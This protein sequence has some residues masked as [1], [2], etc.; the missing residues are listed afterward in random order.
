[1]ITLMKK[2]KGFSQKPIEGIAAPFLPPTPNDLKAWNNT[3]VM[4]NL[5]AIDLKSIR[6]IRDND[7]EYI[8]KYKAQAEAERSKLQK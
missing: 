6:A 4:R 1:M 3:E 2:I 7:T 8:N 5:D